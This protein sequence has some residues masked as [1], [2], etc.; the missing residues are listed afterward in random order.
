[1]GAL[2]RGWLMA[3]VHYNPPVEAKVMVAWGAWL[4]RNPLHHTLCE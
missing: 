1:M 3:G 4:I 2:V